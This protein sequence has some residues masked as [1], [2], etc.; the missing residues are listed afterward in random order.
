MP[1]P[2]D[3]SLL[4]L[5]EQHTGPVK[6][7]HPTEHGGGSDLT[8]VAETEERT[9]FVKAMR[10]RGR[11]G[12]RRDSLLREIAVAPH[13]AGVAPQLLWS[14]TGGR[15]WVVAAWEAVQGRAADLRPGSADLPVVAD[16]LR[17][18][19]ELPLPETA[20]DWPERRWDRFAAGQEHQFAGAALLYTD[21]HPGN[22]V[23][24]EG[25]SWLVDW[26]WPTR[27]AAFISPALLIV[28][29]V[30]A[31]HAPGAAE[32]L[33]RDSPAW[34]EAPT[35][36]VDVFAVAHARMCRTAAACRPEQTWLAAVADAAA[37]WARHRACG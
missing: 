20:A 13:L 11:A 8:A 22:F 1:K 31:G 5:I 33:V 6:R 9:V 19:G 27:G 7:L 34:T 3:P 29:L 32:E 12:G 18:V 28:E 14:E 36:A 2:P 23:V 16:V 21:W 24:G 37:C 30:S 17:R 25:R 10:D 26:S 35:D 4:A 15:E